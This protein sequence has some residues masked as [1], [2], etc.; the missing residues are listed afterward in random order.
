MGRVVNMEA[1]NDVTAAVYNE[2]LSHPKAM[3]EI[4]TRIGTT[5]G[6]DGRRLYNVAA[7]KVRDAFYSAYA[8][9]TDSF[10]SRILAAALQNVNWASLT[11]RLAHQ[12]ELDSRVYS[13]ITSLIRR[14]NGQD[15]D[16]SES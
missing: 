10:A 1:W 8:G 15:P 6:K 16:R 12:G 3:E 13:E 5:K 11:R 2:L 14:S 7:N 4:K 9:K